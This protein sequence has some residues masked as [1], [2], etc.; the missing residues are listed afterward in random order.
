M[1]ILQKLFRK[2]PKPHIPPV[3]SWETIVEM[4]YGQNLSGYADELV[5]V[6]YSKDKSKRYVILK[7]VKGFY[8]YQLEAI[9]PYDPQEWQYIGSD[10]NALPAMWEPLHAMSG[11]SIF[12][13]EEELLNE[14]K[15]EPEYQRYFNTKENNR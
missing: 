7:D 9:Y 8:T 10:E 1:N 11:K 14:M 15:T 2:K 13:R 5:Q 4:M 12:E 6:I 3:P